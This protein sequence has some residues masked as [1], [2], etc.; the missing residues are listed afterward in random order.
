[1]I[2]MLGAVYPWIKAAHLI[3]VIFWLSGLFMLP[4]FYIISRLSLVRLRIGSGSSA[5]GGC[6]RSSSTHP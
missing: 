2:G 3:F 6:D 1:M 5:N 4:R